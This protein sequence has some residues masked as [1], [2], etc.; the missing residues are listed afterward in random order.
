MKKPRQFR[1]DEEL[2]ERFDRIN[3]QLAVN[4]SEVV[5]RLIEEYTKEKEKEM[6]IMAKKMKKVQFVVNAKK[7]FEVDPDK[8]NRVED[9]D[10]V[11]V[12]LDMENEQAEYVWYGEG[13]NPA[14]F[15]SEPD[16]FNGVLELW[17]ELGR[18]GEEE[19]SGK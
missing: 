10:K 12:T 18:P 1:I 5:R 3:D 19:E 9:N 6:K 8:L 7:F 11:L 14:N 13:E 16:D 4:G 2:L 15:P 17:E